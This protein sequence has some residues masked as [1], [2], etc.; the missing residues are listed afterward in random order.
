M[1]RNAIYLS[2]VCH[3]RNNNLNLIR[4]VAAVA[5]LISH[6]WPIS[7]GRGAVQPLTRILH[8]NL[9]QI[10][11]VVFFGISGF[12]IARS[13]ERQPRLGTWVLARIL[14]LF[15]ALAV[16]LLLTTTLLGLLV[17]ELPA[18]DYVTD[19]D[20]YSYILRNLM[21]AFRQAV[22]P[23]VFLD[24]PLARETNGSLWTLQYEVLCYAGVMV[25]GLL[26]AF[27]RWQPRL[28]VAGLLAVAY[29]AAFV[30]PAS[31]LP[32]A[33][34]SFLSLGLPFA[35][36]VSFYLM[37][38][39]LVLHPVVLLGLILMAVAL[40][41]TPLYQPVLDLAVCYG[42]FLLAYMPGIVISRYNSVGDYSYGV[43]IY[44]W[45]V[46]QSVVHFLGPMSPAVNIAIALPIALALAWASWTLV[47]KPALR[48]VPHSDPLPRNG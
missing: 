11:L 33:L 45:P 25:M 7:L 37:R 1:F 39:R 14:R 24:Q 26:G 27:R 31:A 19:P 23:G 36:G 38:D 40:E 2:D 42:V 20:T 9:G 17:T 3:G 16:M 47:E 4:M 34:A 48:L 8:F 10:A 44:A 6:A 15:P 30:L 32:G 22:L 28:A 13:F 35:M 12:L 46:Q 43:Y 41:R 5:V 29:G 18:E 21:L